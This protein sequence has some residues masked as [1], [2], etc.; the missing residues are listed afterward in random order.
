MTRNSSDSP[1]AGSGTLP[2]A[3]YWVP[4]WTSSVASPPSSRIMFGPPSTSDPPRS[5]CSV[6]HQYSSSVSPF[7]ANTGTPRGS[8]AVPFGP[9]TTAAAA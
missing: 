5:A 3:S 7:Q 1:L 6:H 2:S 9:T 4:W 8:S